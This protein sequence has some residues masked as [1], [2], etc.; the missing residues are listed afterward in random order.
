MMSVIANTVA[1]STPM[2]AS[3]TMGRLADV[4]GDRGVDLRASRAA[5]ASRAS[6]RAPGSL[7]AHSQHPT[8]ALTAKEQGH[9]GKVERQLGIVQPQGAHGR[10]ARRGVE[11]LDRDLGDEVRR[12]PHHAVQDRPHWPEGPVGRVSRRL[13]E[14]LWLVSLGKGRRGW[15]VSE[16]ISDRWSP[17][18][19][20]TSGPCALVPPTCGDGGRAGTR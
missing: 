10:V 14:R 7:L 13:L 19:G 16:E 11:V 1:A 20:G 2:S 12:V 17:S 18:A 3:A 8:A 4:S 15:A 6:L 5:R 9:P